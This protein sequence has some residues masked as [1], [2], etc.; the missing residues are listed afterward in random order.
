MSYM[1]L[2]TKA[3]A[4]LGVIRLITEYHDDEKESFGVF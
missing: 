3:K 4:A 1:R 2:S